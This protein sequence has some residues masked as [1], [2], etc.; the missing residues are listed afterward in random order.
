MK[1]CINNTIG[2]FLSYLFSQNKLNIKLNLNSFLDANYDKEFLIQSKLLFQKNDLTK[3]IWHKNFFLK[4]PKVTWRLNSLNR[5]IKRLKL[6]RFDKKDQKGYNNLFFFSDDILSK[7]KKIKVFLINFFINSNPILSFFNFFTLKNSNQIPKD[8]FYFYKFK[9]MIFNFKKR[10]TKLTNIFV[11]LKKLKIIKKKYFLKNLNK[12]YFYNNFYFN[13]ISFNQSIEKFIRQSKQHEFNSN[14]TWK[15]HYLNAD[16]KY[17]TF[18]NQNYFLNSLGKLNS[19]L[20]QFYKKKKFN[21]CYLTPKSLLVIFVSFL[22][23]PVSYRGC[24]CCNDCF[25]KRLFFLSESLAEGK[26]NSCRA[27]DS[28]EATD[29]CF[30]KGKTTTGG[31]RNP[32]H[33]FVIED[34][35]IDRSFQ[36][37]QNL[38]PVNKISKIPSFPGNQTL[39]FTLDFIELFISLKLNLFFK[40]CS[41]LNKDLLIKY[42]RKYKAKHWITNKIAFSNFGTKVSYKYFLGKKIK[43]DLFNKYSYKTNKKFGNFKINKSFSISQS[44]SKSFLLDLGIISNRLMNLNK[45]LKSVYFFFIKNKFDFFKNSFFRMSSIPY[46]NIQIERFLDLWSFLKKFKKKMVFYFL[47]FLFFIKPFNSN[48]KIPLFN[49]KLLSFLNKPFRSTDDPQF[50]FQRKNCLWVTSKSRVNFLNRLNFNF[51]LNNSLK[52]IKIGTNFSHFIIK[53]YNWTIFEIN[54]LKFLVN[55]IVCLNLLN[56]QEILNSLNIFLFN[57]LLDWSKKQHKNNSN[58]WIFN[59]Y[60]LFLQP[61][62]YFLLKKIVSKQVKNFSN[63]SKIKLKLLKK[64]IM[65]EKILFSKT[66]F[67]LLFSSFKLENKRLIFRF[68]NKKLQ[69]ISKNTESNYSLN[70]SSFLQKKEKLEITLAEDKIDDKFSSLTK[71]LNR[72]RKHIKKKFL[73]KKNFLV[74]KNPSDLKK[75]LILKT[76]YLEKYK[77]KLFL[78]KLN[79]TLPFLDLEKAMIFNFSF[80]TQLKKKKKRI[81]NFYLNQI[82]IHIKICRLFETNFCFYKKNPEFFLKNFYT[83]V[84]KKNVKNFIY[85]KIRLSL[86]NNNNYFKQT[87][88]F[89]IHPYKETFFLLNILEKM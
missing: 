38:K 2:V 66:K 27:T 13:K 72:N 70:E 62:A 28:F 49:K 18:F 14:F 29:D 60:W 48:K 74:L 54:F 47:K 56:N 81:R 65:K 78:L 15:C 67:F 61:F 85:R 5:K 16:K 22:A 57:F 41:S 59:K 86:V 84:F 20:P 88:K 4:Q 3:F 8:F 9:F 17:L 50:F 83:K 7:S 46:V 33:S 23:S 79:L 82:L 53:G 21:L 39:L 89:S 19:I 43:C 87:V 80:I 1:L 11:I 40:Q 77:E 32:W 64:K 75:K 24:C 76:W 31:L 34:S 55:K 42:F 26:N 44:N 12:I 30:Y 69:L 25:S 51:R 63:N 37:K 71:L 58:T 68:R 10:K 45:T 36:I 6:S 52:L 35:I 73:S